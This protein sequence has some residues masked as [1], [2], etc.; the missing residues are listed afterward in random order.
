M[1]RPRRP[2][3]A[4]ARLSILGLLVGTLRADP[5]LDAAIGLYQSKQYPAAQVALAKLAMVASPSPAACYYLGM[6]LRHR[7]DGQALDAALPWLEKAVALA[8]ENSTYVGDYGGTCFQLADKHR[9][10]SFATRGRNA[11]EKA[12]ALDPNN[13]DARN[14]LMQFYAR[15]PWPLG[16]QSRAYEQA[17]EIARRD[18]AQAVHTYLVLGRSF[19]KVGDRGAARDAYATALK[20]GPANAEATAGVARLGA[21]ARSADGPA[22]AKP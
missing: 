15:A 12:I 5:A 19:E 3:G 10:F 9:S 4:L 14:G 21:A 7:G 8:P 1:A 20:F 13:L 6:T 16:S 17:A 2:A 11:M 22:P 18:P